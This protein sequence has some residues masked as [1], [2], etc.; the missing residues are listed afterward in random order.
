MAGRERMWRE[1]ALKRIAELDRMIGAEMTKR[2]EVVNEGRR[3]GFPTM[4][5]ILAV[6]CFVWWQFG[7]R[8]PHLEEFHRASTQY[9]LYAGVVLAV[10]AAARTA[11]Y[12]AQR[13]RRA[14]DGYA[15]STERLQAWQ[16]ERRDLEKRLE[17]QAHNKR[18]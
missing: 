11:F 6:V 13:I 14:P 10:I 5:W 2:T 16:N 3:F 17:E 18:N 7:A 12:L 1:Q 9:V 8:I 4:N 15:D